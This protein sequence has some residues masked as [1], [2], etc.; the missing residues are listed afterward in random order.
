MAAC[1]KDNVTLQDGIT[2]AKNIAE[3]IFDNTFE[4]AIWITIDDI[5]SPASQSQEE[6]QGIHPMDTGHC[7]RKKDYLIPHV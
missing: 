1:G 7:Y 2:Q 5:N 3:G 4:T 6:D